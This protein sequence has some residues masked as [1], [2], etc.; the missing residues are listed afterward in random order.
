MT[1]A[2]ATRLAIR[3]GR[4]T[5]ST[6]G[7]APGF[8]QCN[9]VVLDRSLAFDF[10]VYCQRNQKACPVLE[11][12]DPGDPEPRQLAP[13]ADLRT[14]LPRYAVYRNGRREADRKDIRD[15]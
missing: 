10:L 6:R 1:P 7:L 14:D 11:V 9:L 8:V 3:E 12:T 2:Q 4:H 5:G 13:G 15:L